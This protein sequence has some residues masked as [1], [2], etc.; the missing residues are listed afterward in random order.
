MMTRIDGRVLRNRTMSVLRPIGKVFVSLAL[1]L[2]DALG[3]G[4]GGTASASSFAPVVLPQSDAKP[5]AASFSGK[6]TTPKK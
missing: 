5:A 2:A 1:L 3:S 6:T 4:S